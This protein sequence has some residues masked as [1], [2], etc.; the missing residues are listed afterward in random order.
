ML[1]TTD[2]TRQI[3]LGIILLVLSA[4]CYSTAGLF[5]RLIDTSVWTMLCLR[6]LVAGVFILAIMLARDGRAGLAQFSVFRSLPGLV[7]VSASVLAMVFNLNAYLNTSVANVVLIYATAPFVAAA[8][9]WVLLREP[10]PSVTLWASLVALAGV[11]VIVGGSLGGGGLLGDVYAMAMTTFM[12]LMIV[13]VRWGKAQSMVAMACASA[14]ASFFITLPF[15][16]FN[17]VTGNTL[18]LLV[19][20]GVTQLGLGI[21]FLTLGARHLNSGQAAL[22]STLDVPLAP[23]WV[24]IAFADVP[25]LTTLLGGL[26][27]M[28]AVIFSILHN[29]RALAPATEG[30]S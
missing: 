12:A 19:T 29:Q 10:V 14:F 30:T 13:A 25:P 15:A 5:T 26:V 4:I 22:I 6:G 21:L 2:T 28:A 3:R 18:M 27:V 16:D 7:A 11:T 24:W 23:L 8:F 9:S 20:F 1:N 17:P